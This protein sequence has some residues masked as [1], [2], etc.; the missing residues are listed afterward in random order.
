MKH[1]V[2]IFLILLFSCSNDTSTTEEYIVI[3]DNTILEDTIV[4]NEP[5]SILK[6]GSYTDERLSHNEQEEFLAFYQKFTQ[7]IIE[8]NL[9][10][11][12]ECINPDGLYFIETNGAMPLVQK[13]FDVKAFSKKTPVTTF[14]NL[15]FIDIKNQPIFD[16]LPK[17]ICAGEIY[18]KY[19]CF[20]KVENTLKESGL[21]N[22]SDLNEKEI[23]AIELAANSI[24]LTVRNTQNFTFYFSKTTQGWKLTFLDIRT[25]CEA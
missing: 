8:T 22:Y 13:V 4:V 7:A 21:W 11:V 6:K 19:G 24:N 25:P 10:A 3:S 14:F 2:W 12:N 9:D 20:S 15:G 17:V 1:L 18:D 16:T 5:D 23:Q